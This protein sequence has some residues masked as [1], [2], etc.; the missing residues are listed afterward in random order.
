MGNCPSGF[1]PVGLQC[2]VTCSSEDS[3]TNRLVN[4]EPRC[5]YTADDTKYFV[6]KQAPSFMLQAGD[7]EPTMEWVRTNRAGQYPALKEAEDDYTA[8][9]SVLMTTIS[10][11]RL[12]ADAFRQLQAA[13]NTRAAN[14]QGYQAARN[15]YYTLTQGES[16]AATERQRVLNAEVLPEITPYLQS[17]NFLAERQTQ[18]AGTKTA[19]DAVK[20]RLISLKDDFRTTTTT[21]MKQVTELQNQIELQKRRTIVQQ[22]QT[23]DWVVNTLIVILSLVV[24]YILYRRIVGPSKPAPTKSVSSASTSRGVQTSAYTS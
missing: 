1:T 12:I 22:A 4:G 10:R 24:I 18:Q 9:R 14:P 21:L 11:D 3:L 23:N 19:V 8:K 6:L 15:R 13:E 7:P 20:S 5:T 2:V 17:I 16:W